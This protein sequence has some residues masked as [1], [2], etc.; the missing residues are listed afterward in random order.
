MHLNYFSDSMGVYK[1]Y[2]TYNGKP[3]YYGPNG[4]RLYF[5][6]GSGWLVGASIGA[7]T[8]FPSRNGTRLRACRQ[9]LLCFEEAFVV[10]RRRGAGK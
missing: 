6:N 10:P 4:K 1:L 2:S 5:I 8:G 3:S 9:V 7:G